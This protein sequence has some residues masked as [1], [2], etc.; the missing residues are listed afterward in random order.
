MPEPRADSDS[1]ACV[2]DQSYKGA[3]QARRRQSGRLHAAG[4]PSL[5]KYGA[6]VIAR[7]SG[8]SFARYSLCSVC[9]ARL[10]ASTVSSHASPSVLFISLTSRHSAGCTSASRSTGEL[11]RSLLQQPISANCGSQGY[12]VG[13]SYCVAIGNLLPLSTFAEPTCGCLLTAL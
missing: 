2:A 9:S 3:I 12:I 13:Q 11:G 5:P 6:L 1:L 7:S 8:R 10:I 4:V